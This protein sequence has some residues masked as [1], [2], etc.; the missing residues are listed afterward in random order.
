MLNHLYGGSLT[1]PPSGTPLTGQ[2][3]AFDQAAFMNPQGVLKANENTKNIFSL[4]STWMQNTMALFNPLNFVSSFN[5]SALQLPGIT[6]PGLTGLSSSAGAGFGFDAQGYVY[7]PANCNKGKKC[8]IHV[9]LHG[10]KQG[11]SRDISFLMFNLIF[12]FVLGKSFVGDVFAK[13]AGYLEVAELNDI[14]VLFPQIIASSLSS[15]PNGC[16]DWWGYGSPQYA[17]KSGPQMVGIKKMINTVRA[18]NLASI[19]EE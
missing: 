2:F 7:F 4:W 17:T 12:L 13:Q 19:S 3:M 11:L 10:C 5:M 15:N 6:L 9:A 14:I 8:S 18:I 16:F 1:K